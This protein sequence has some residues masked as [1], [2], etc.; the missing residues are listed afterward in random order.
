M[1]GDAPR[2]TREPLSSRAE[3]CSA[4]GLEN[5]REHKCEKLLTASEKP[6]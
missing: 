5:A 6:L 1:P 3:P 4:A 2:N